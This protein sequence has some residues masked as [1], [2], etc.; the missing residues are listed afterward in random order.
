MARKD[1]AAKHAARLDAATAVLRDGR[2]QTFD[3]WIPKDAKPTVTMLRDSSVGLAQDPRSPPQ[4]PVPAGTGRW[5]GL[6]W[7]SPSSA[8]PGRTFSH[9]AASP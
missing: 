1:A 3:D 8:D 2:D 5:G 7:S 9:A 4:R 6:C